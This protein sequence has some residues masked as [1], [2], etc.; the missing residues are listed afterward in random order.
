MHGKWE[1]S[2]LASKNCSFKTIPILADTSVIS[3]KMRWSNLDSSKSFGYSLSSLYFIYLARFI[4]SMMLLSIPKFF[5]CSFQ[6][7]KMNH[8]SE[9]PS[10]MGQNYHR[11]PTDSGRLLVSPIQFFL[12]LWAWP[13]PTWKKCQFQRSSVSKIRPWNSIFQP[14]PF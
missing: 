8:G 9:L 12:V 10:K 13:K 7:C 6:K 14:H 1:K 5:C 4:Y 11:K 2:P 3:E